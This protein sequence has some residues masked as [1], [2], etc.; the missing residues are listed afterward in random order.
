MIIDIFGW[1]GMLL[2]LVAYV[3]LSTNK[4]NNGKLYQ[5]IN[6]VAAVFMAIGL[7]PKDAW[8]SFALQ[9]AWGCIAL[10]TLIKI[11]RKK[12]NSK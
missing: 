7:F 8:F 9:V 10:I 3:L 6:L 11:I 5:I 4:I 1:I 2:V 12:E